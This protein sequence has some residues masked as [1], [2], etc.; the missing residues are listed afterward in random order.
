MNPR[1]VFLASFVFVLAV[2]IS[3][4]SFLSHSLDVSTYLKY[5]Q[6]VNA[7]PIFAIVVGAGAPF[8]ITY[9]NARG[10]KSDKFLKESNFHALIFTCLLLLCLGVVRIFLDVEL[11]Y[12]IALLI[13]PFVAIKQNLVSFFL[14]DNRLRKCASVRVNQRICTAIIVVIAISIPFDPIVVLFTSLVLGELAGALLLV[15]TCKEFGF[16]KSQPLRKR[17]RIIGSRSFF[18]NFFSIG[19]SAIPIPALSLMSSN[20]QEQSQAALAVLLIR[21]LLLG[22]GPFFQLIVPKVTP[23]KN[24]VRALKVIFY[25]CIASLAVFGLLIVVLNKYIGGFIL[26][27]F[28]D[29]PDYLV[30][31]YLGILLLGYPALISTSFIA[32]FCSAI[33]LVSKVMYVSFMYFVGLLV[34]CTYAYLMN[35][36]ITRFLEFIVLLQYLIMSIYLWI[37]YNELSA[38]KNS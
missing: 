19:A 33:G 12:F 35:F 10:L 38:E 30:H 17:D 28:F 11:A 37:S 3:L 32:A 5:Q 18:S 9:F 34:I 13:S 2:D 36:D 26:S 4:L 16:V 15:R 20:I 8:A 31:Q 23:K 7:A 6:I 21:Y 24:D 1:G 14:G 22:L 29:S 25:I 27:F